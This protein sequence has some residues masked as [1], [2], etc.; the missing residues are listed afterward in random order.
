LPYP[1]REKVS[2]PTSLLVAYQGLDK[3]LPGRA[4][5]EVSSRRQKTAAFSLGEDLAQVV[6]GIG[7]CFSRSAEKKG[8]RKERPFKNQIC[9]RPFPASCLPFAMEEGRTVGAN[10]R[11]LVVDFLNLGN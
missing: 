5:G 3:R 9:R 7:P 4:A 2:S 10:S 11:D 1:S 6:E 8:G